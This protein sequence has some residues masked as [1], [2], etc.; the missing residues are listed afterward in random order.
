MKNLQYIKFHNQKSSHP[1]FDLVKLEKLLSHEGNPEITQLHKIGF[2]HILLITGG[3]GAHT[4]DF[5]DYP[6]AKGTLLTVR[7]DQVHRFFKS[8]DAKGHILL[9]TE[10]FL[11][12]HFSKTEVLRSFQLFNELLSSPKLELNQS[13]FQEILDLV[14]QIESEYKEHEDEFSIGIIR[15]A[16][17]MLVIK[18]FR[19]KARKGNKLVKRK[20]LPEFLQ[21]QKLVEEKGFETRK[22]SDYAQLMNCTTKTLNNFCRAIVDKSAKAVIDEIVITQIKRLLI[23]TPLSITEI[24]YAAGFNEPTNFYKYFKKHSNSSPEVFRKTYA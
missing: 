13:D 22:A 10:D 7:K 1:G 9:F 11:A 6:Y 18:L 17:H 14:L 3:K 20:Y 8:T 5:T 24:A 15:S 21:F 12:S 2:F 19:I 23:N 4:I 16:L